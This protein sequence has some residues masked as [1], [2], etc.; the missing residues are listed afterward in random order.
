VPF[1]VED[2][3]EVEKTAPSEPLD[4]WKFRRMF[5]NARAGLSS[6]YYLARSDATP[7]ASV[8]TFDVGVESEL[9]LFDFLALQ[10]GL[11]FALDR[12]EYQ[13]SPSNPSSIVYASSVLGIPLMAKYIFNPS[14][15]RTLGLYLGAYATLPLMGM[16]DPPPFGLLGGMDMAVKTGLGVLLF[17][18]RYSSDL[19]NTSV[20]DNAIA[21]YRMFLTLS[22]GYK[23]GLF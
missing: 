6:R 12:A 2:I 21:Y 5:F 22:V 7:N 20:V 11:S 17:D 9:R 13:R 4:A 3:R 1:Y 10:L 14:P 19:G 16:A 18:L 15:L 8:I 23:F